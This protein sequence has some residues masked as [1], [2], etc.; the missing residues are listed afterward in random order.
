MPHTASIPVV[1]LTAYDSPELR[2]AAVA[3]GCAGF[4]AKPIDVKT[5]PSE[6][7]GFIAASKTG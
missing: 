4:I 6:I 1:A 5:F 2:E 7:A 3:A